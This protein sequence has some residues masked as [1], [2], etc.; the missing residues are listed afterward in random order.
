[1]QEVKRLE[2]LIS[3]TREKLDMVLDKNIDALDV[4]FKSPSVDFDRKLVRG[5]VIRLFQIKEEK[6]ARALEEVAGGKL[7]SVVVE[8]EAIASN[9]LKRNSFGKAVC[10]IPNNKI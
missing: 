9:L 8:T 5:R 10:L 7:F 3:A 2:D 4:H 6:Y 1:L